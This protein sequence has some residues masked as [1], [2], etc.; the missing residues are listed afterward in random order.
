MVLLVLEVVLVLLAAYLV[1][2]LPL[3]RLMLGEIDEIQG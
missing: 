2:F 3:A 1:R